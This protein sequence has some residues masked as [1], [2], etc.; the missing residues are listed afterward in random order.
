MCSK[1]Q[2]K[3]DVILSSYSSSEETSCISASK[4]NNRSKI[5]HINTHIF[6]ENRRKTHLQRFKVMVLN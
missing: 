6:R 2:G 1:L 3:A 5:T 4:N